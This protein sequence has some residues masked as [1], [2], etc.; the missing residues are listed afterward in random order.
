MREYRPVEQM[1]TNAVEVTPI[2][3]DWSV[4]YGETWELIYPSSDNLSLEECK[5]VLE[6]SGVT[7]PD[8]NPYE[9]DREQLL[10]LLQAEEDEYLEQNEWDLES[11]REE[12]INQI[13]DETIDGI[14]DWREAVRDAWS[15]S[16]DSF[17][18]MM[19]YRYPLPDYEGDEG[20]DQF[21][22]DQ[23]HIP[24]VLVRYNDEVCLAL[25]GGGM[26]LADKICEAYMLLGYL[27]P[28][29]FCGSLPE[30]AGETMTER[31]AWMIE[32]CIRSA[33]VAIYRAQYAKEKLER[34][35][36]RLA[37]GKS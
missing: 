37:A 21:I 19:N 1:W 25:S 16:P 17:E 22:L 32:G 18:P 13:N 9:M 10:E 36:D 31:R 30:N 3:T 14:E 5:A 27:P 24:L 15:E 29:H 11:I 26:N 34:Y 33:D 7:L 2:E 4:G 8:P 35:R 6:E 12:A 28:L 23:E 20:V